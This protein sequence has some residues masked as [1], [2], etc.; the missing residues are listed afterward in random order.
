MANTVSGPYAPTAWVDGT[1]A[2]NQTRM[3]NL[4]GQSKVALASLNPDHITAAFVESG[5]TAVKDATTATTL[6]VMTGVAWLIMTD[7]T[8]AKISC[9]Q[10]TFTT[11]TIN[12]T[13]YLDLNPDGSWSWA[14]SHSAQANYLPICQVTTDGSG[15]ISGVTDKRPTTISQWQNATAALYGGGSQTP[16]PLAVTTTQK[17]QALGTVVGGVTFAQ[18]GALKGSSDTAAL[19][20]GTTGYIVSTLTSD[21]PTGA[22]AFS[23]ECWMKFAANPAASNDFYMLGDFDSGNHNLF[24]QLQTTG[25]VKVLSNS[26]PATITSNAALTTN[27]WHHLV[28]TYDG[29][30]LRLYIDGT[31]QTATNTTTLAMGY[32]GSYPYVI[33]AT[34]SGATH[35]TPQGFFAGSLDEIA[36]YTG[37]ALSGAQVTAHYNAGTAQTTDTYRSVVLGDGATRYYRLGDAS[38]SATAVC[39]TAPTPTTLVDAGG[40]LKSVGGQASVGTLGAPVIVAQAVNTPVTTTTTQ[41]I[42]AFTPPAAGFYRVSAAFTFSNSASTTLTLITDYTDPNAGAA[43]GYFLRG[44]ATGGILNGMSF[45]AGTTTIATFPMTIYAS[46]SAP[47]AVYFHDAAGIPNDHVTVIIERLI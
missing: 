34:T 29:V 24:F 38:G 4:E 1:T 43:F 16:G 15:N 12:T 41:Q 28:A 13:Y 45:L 30:T 8:L 26:G 39:T 6:D 9:P 27:V 40:T 25:F 22:G 21:L 2:L 32:V 37:V 42:T 14:T 11:V 17:A 46:S 33:G 5:L 20:N 35:T 31:L 18:A 47:I 36:L 10:T 23:M 7:G 19:F 44:D 3:N